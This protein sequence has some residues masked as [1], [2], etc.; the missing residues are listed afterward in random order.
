MR[1]LGPDGQPVGGSGSDDGQRASAEVQ[2]IVTRAKSIA[3]QGDPASALQQMAFAFQT[4]VTSNLVLDT[5]CDLLGEI[6]VTMGALPE[7]SEELQMFDQ[8]RKNRTDP[9]SYYQIGNRFLQLQQPFLSRPFLAQAK[10]LLGSDMSELMQATDMSYAQVAMDLGQYE[11]AIASFHEMNDKYGGLPVWLVMEMT[12]CYA[13]LRQLD[14]AESVYQI[15]PAEATEQFEGMSEVREEI[16]DLL[17]RVRDF[18]E[19]EGDLGLRAWNYV[20]T[21][22]ML[23][24]TNPDEK[25]PGERFVFFQPSE[26][27][28]AYICGQTAALLDARGYAPSRILWLGATSEPLAR[29]FAQWWEV[30]PANVRAYQRGDNH[31]DEQDLGLLVMSHSYNVVELGDDES[32]ID[33]AVARA[34]LIVFA[35]DTHWTDRQPMAPDISGFMAQ[36]CNLPWEDRLLVAEDQSM[37]PV[38][39]TR[40]AET[41]AVDVA[42]QF[43]VEEECDEFATELWQDYEVCTDLILDHRDGTLNRRPLVTHS[44]I[45]SPRFGY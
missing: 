32:L 3:S 29:I 2:E 16:G 12:E 15:A 45:K 1:I 11:E 6:A 7:Q 25:C 43:P 23:V 10:A 18:D 33:L 36:I 40:D 39:E 26:E 34:G 20:Q 17:A 9:A 5:T 38:T 19:V 27:D 21:R 42:K 22:S 35:L 4:D 44:P 14:E 37:T 31:D 30:E 28:V 13:L 8:I 24:E 41:V